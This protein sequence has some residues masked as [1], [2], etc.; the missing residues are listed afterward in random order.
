M[1]VLDNQGMENMSTVLQFDPYTREILWSYKGDE[2]NPFFTKAL[3]SC[4]RLPNGN[5][6]I[7]ES[8]MGRAFEVIPEGEIVWEFYNPYRAGDNNELIATLIDVFRVP[9]ESVDSWLSR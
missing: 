7:T 9:T 2:E 8:T 3:G 1:L 4:Q 5:T 6:L